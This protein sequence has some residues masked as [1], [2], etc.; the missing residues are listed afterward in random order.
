MKRD[1]CIVLQNTDET[2]QEI[3]QLTEVL[4]KQII[5]LQMISGFRAHSVTQGYFLLH[6]FSLSCLFFFFKEKDNDERFNTMNQKQL[7]SYNIQTQ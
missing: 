5:T 7:S 1:L 3:K 6:F 2:V 4:P